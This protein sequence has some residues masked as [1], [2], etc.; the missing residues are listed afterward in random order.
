MVDDTQAR[1]L[2]SGA[3]VIARLDSGFVL[4]P[5]VVVAR[6]RERDPQAIV[7]DHGGATPEQG[8]DDDYDDPRYAVPDDLVW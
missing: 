6:V 8:G 1:Q 7:L 3:L 2:A 5:R 4:L